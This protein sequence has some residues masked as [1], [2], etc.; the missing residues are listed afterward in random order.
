MSIY[1][2]A[3]NEDTQDGWR[4]LKQQWPG[5]FYILNDHLAFVAPQDVNEADRIA[6]ILGMSDQKQVAGFVLELSGEFQGYNDNALWD[7]IDKVQ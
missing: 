3:L 2:V 1:L 7:W 6:T 4:V 5:R